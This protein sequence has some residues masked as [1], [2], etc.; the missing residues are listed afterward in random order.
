MSQ[1]RIALG[2][3][4]A[5]GRKAVNQDFHGCRVPRE[6]QLS[7][8]GIA[9]AMA[10]GISSSAVS[11]VASETAVKSLLDDYYATSE[12]WSVRHAVERV[13]TATNAWLHAQS[14][15]GPHR[16][17]PDRGYVCTLSALVIKATT[18]HLFHVGD[19]R[20]YRLHADSLE[21]LTQDHRLWLSQTESQLS[22]ALGADALV[23]IDY[24]ALPL[25]I[26]DTFLLATDGVYEHLSAEAILHSV[27]AHRDDLDEA[28]RH[29]VDQ[30][31]RQGSEDNLSVQLVRIEALPHTAA[32]PLHREVE[33]L[34][35]PPLLEP[36]ARFD[37]YRILRELHAS[38]RSHVYLALDE[39]SGTRV[40]L[41]TPSI[42]LRDDPGYLE[43]LLMEEWLARRIN[44]RH[45][46]KAA[47]PDRRRHYLYTVTEY[48][49]GQT[50]A[51]WLRDNPAPDLE[52][53]RGIVEQVARGLQALHRREVLH[54]DLRPENLMIDATG[55]VTLIDL[56]AARIAGIVESA[57]TLESSPLPG[58][59]LYMA[60][61]YFLGE[62]GTTRSD[63]YSLG[64]L[65]Y[66]M[67]AGRFP[68]GTR[69]ARTRTRDDQRRLTYRSVLD[70]ERA[71]PAWI[72]AT[73]SRALH[74]HPEKRYQALSEFVHDLRR[75]NP[76]YLNRTRPPLI[77]RHPV[78]F[79][80]GLSAILAVVIL[81]LLAR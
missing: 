45:V 20:I 79:W 55:T 18:A 17:A 56:G 35:L 77:E 66:R 15:Q 49:E 3:H 29:I 72:D 61:E 26:G 42:D 44:S 43:R 21:P 65:T 14:R 34:P 4:S 38:S 36:R 51:Q 11:Q 19:T 68:Y 62:V 75:P 32:P 25:A 57:T 69:V 23:E 39:A 13:L 81:A 73:L 50:L 12:A 22:R 1:L 63:L 64:V 74:P 41:K 70:E 54:Q 47:L 58:T 9:L 71:I 30:A 28:A 60:P 8:Q 7:L 27:A 40:V 37:G 6:P 59:A 80:Q 31:Y 33:E 78:A 5:P 67:L 16:Y 48:L 46:L 52:T 24:R 10:D 2:Q 53:V 76:T